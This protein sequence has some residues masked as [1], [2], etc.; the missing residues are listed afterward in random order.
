[1]NVTFWGVRGSIAC[2]QPSHLRYG[3]N[4]SCV[5][6]K[7]GDRLLI[8]DAGTGLREL[9]QQL[10]K[11]PDKPLTMLLTHTH[12]DHIAG[13]PF[14]APAYSAQTILNIYAGHLKPESSIADTLN[15]VMAPPFFPISPGTFRA[16]IAYH[17]FM[18]GDTLE[19][20][21]GITVRT[22]PLNHPDRA[23]GYRINYKGRSVC[24]ITDT[25]HPSDGHDQNILGLIAGA[26]LVI[27]DASYTDESYPRFQGWGHST[28]Q[29]GVRLCQLAG[30][31]RLALFHHD[32]EHDDERLD[33]IA[34]EALELWQPT[35]VAREHE[36]I[37]L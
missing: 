27:Y 3:G 20:G 9:G 8:L 21:D 1:M 30:V 26:D 28:W 6:V 22:A 13:L 5:T 10:G 4:T 29:E 33:A 34:A 32:P 2:P 18:A 37:A 35:F 11:N 31:K 24:Y 15:R 14:F 23:T 12:F 7:C 25:E 36:V 16:Q 17:D 19:L